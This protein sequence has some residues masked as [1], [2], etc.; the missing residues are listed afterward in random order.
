[1]L[2]ASYEKTE[3][4]C[5]LPV[6]LTLPAAVLFDRTD[7]FLTVFFSLALHEFAHSFM[8]KRLGYIV[9]AIEIQPFGFIARLDSPPASPQEAIAVYAS[10]P[11]LS[12]LLALSAA[13]LMQLGRISSPLLMQFSSFNL[14]L[15]I[16]NLIPVLPLDGGRLLVSLFSKGPSAFKAEK[17]FSSFGIFFGIILMAAGIFLL[18]HGNKNFTFVSAGFFIMSAAVRE[19]RMHTL[20]DTK[21]KLKQLSRLRRGRS[22][23][24]VFPMAI[25][26]RNTVREAFGALSGGGYNVILLIDADGKVC[27]MLDESDISKALSL[28]S[29]DKKLSEIY[30]SNLR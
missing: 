4:R 5:S 25:S 16:V 11:V 13:G 14:V 26:S 3:L 29:A 30:R 9:T 15:G 17:F 8:A 12:L 20:S 23:L 21:T 19:L 10:G 1:M 22:A 6:L 27:G 18:V 24:R 28:G 2:I 7:T